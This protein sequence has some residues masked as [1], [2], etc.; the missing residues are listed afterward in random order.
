[1]SN[2]SRT[3]FACLLSD[4]LASRLVWRY[5]AAGWFA[6]RRATSSPALTL[7]ILVGLAS[8]IALLSSVPAYS[9]GV[10]DR[11]LRTEFQKTEGPP[12]LSLRIK[13]RE[14]PAR[15]TTVDQYRRLDAYMTGSAAGIIGVPIRRTV[16]SGRTD[17]HRI[18]PWSVPMTDVYNPSE[19]RYARMTFIDGLADQI[20]I[21]EGTGLDDPAGTELPVLISESAFAE[22]ELEVGERYWFIGPDAKANEKIGFR[23][24]GIWRAKNPS[25]REFWADSNP[26]SSYTFDLMVTE[27]D[28]FTRVVPAFEHPKLGEYSW[29]LAL[30]QSALRVGQVS[31]M[32][33]ALRNVELDALRIMPD[34]KM[35][36][37]PIS[38]L[39][40]L[41]R[42]NSELTSLLAIASLPLLAT[43]VFYALVASGMVITH[44][45]D[46][47]SLLRSRG[48]TLLQVVMS[49][50]AERG[51]V[52]VVALALGVAIGALIAQAIGLSSGFLVFTPRRPLPVVVDGSALQF[53]AVALVV[54]IVASIAPAIQAAGRS[55]VAQ[56][57]RSARAE[58]AGR[59]TGVGFELGLL[60]AS[61][62]AFRLMSTGGAIALDSTAQQAPVEPSVLIVPAA[63]AMSLCLLYRRAIGPITRVVASIIGD[64]G[65]VPLLLAL[66]QIGRSPG[67]EV[68][69]ALLVSLT[70]ALGTYSASLARTME[71]NLTDRV[72]YGTPS[73]L[74]LA[75]LWETDP[76]TGALLEPPLASVDVPGIEAT[77]RVQSYNG[78]F[79]F[80]QRRATSV[81][82]LGVDSATFAGVAWWRSDLADVS[83][84]YLM[85]LMATDEAAAIVSRDALQQFQV[86]VGDSINIT[87]TPQALTSPQAIEFH[88]VAALDYFPSLYPAS[89]PFI[90]A[91]LDYLHDQMGLTP[92]SIWARLRPGTNVRELESL[93]GDKGVLVIG[94][95]E[96]SV[97]LRQAMADPTV[98]G[99]LGVL[100]VG[101]LLS[102]GL[103]VLGYLLHARLSLA[104]RVPQFGVLRT[105]GLSRGGLV[106]TLLLETL[107]VVASSLVGGVAIGLAMSRV[108]VPFAQDSLDRVDKAPPFVVVTPTGE[109]QLLAVCALVMVAL[110]AATTVGLVA[111]MRLHEA[112]KL[113]ERG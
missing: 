64:R 89:G 44:Y 7:F 67:G 73:D 66:R 59:V 13:H 36:I 86:R 31:E 49:F 46:E 32:R 19:A 6:F 30:D 43:A 57:A 14:D 78:R 63:M 9:G 20:E 41:I 11:L 104:R 1:M 110:G 8:S 80:D 68:G 105:M 53:G 51:I 79:A 12:P 72:R 28:F 96:R 40:F 47:I 3:T 112:A 54:A 50:L 109:L 62:Y 74:Q 108:F 10:A 26:E 24:N 61:A 52:G 102:A 2:T 94:S 22:T 97:V 106:A 35:D 90:V 111:R 75:L 37:T 15:P 85:S 71:A 23:I 60:A 77:T 5:A 88:V 27:K 101:F 29:F 33:T 56:R 45:E 42:R 34:T 65:P 25:N 48:A 103:S 39:D 70:F 18:N 87:F 76:E 81:Q 16:R 84:E 4:I 113:G 83:P 92:Y 99:L 69:V 91:N 58:L 95:K 38:S 17:T 100:T 93:I 82:V 55:I 107:L 98:T 21:V